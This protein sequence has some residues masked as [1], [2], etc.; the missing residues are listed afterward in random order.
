MVLNEMQFFQL[1]RDFLSDYLIMRRNL[2][3]KTVHAYRQSL[4]Q[5]AKYLHDE[6]GLCFDALSFYHFSRSNVY[7]FLVWLREERGCSAKTLNLRLSAIKSFLKFCGE[8]SIDLMVHYL[9]V[10]SIHA[11]KEIEQ[12]TVKYLTQPQLKQLFDMPDIST[13]LGRRN[14]FILLFTYE[15][16]MRLQELL[17]L[18]YCSVLRDGKFVRIRIKGKGLKVRYVPLM[19]SMVKH[20]DAYLAEFHSYPDSH[21]FLIYTIHDHQHTQMKP[22]TI[23]YLMKKYGKLARRQDRE[24]PD[25]LHAHMLRHSIAMT[26]YKK[27]IPI[28]YIGDFLGHSSIDTTKVYSH[29][30]DETIAH[31][32][33]SV[34]QLSKSQKPVPTKNWKS[35]EQYLREYCGLN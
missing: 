17:D 19:D 13:K 11:F 28:S 5:M 7:D 24:F 35:K 20:L 33:A 31:A 29:A 27:G 12:N 18:E 15:T 9:D 32:L 8:E 16:G 2:S 22:G 4:N 10:S 21:D 6:K 34:D 3:D 23:D 14:R 25:Q 26:M 30:D 1:L